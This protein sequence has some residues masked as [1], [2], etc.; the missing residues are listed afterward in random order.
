MVPLSSKWSRWIDGD[1][2][3]E[4]RRWLGTTPD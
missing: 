1:A 2:G 4:G 3:N